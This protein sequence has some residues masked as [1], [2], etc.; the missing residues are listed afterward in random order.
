LAGLRVERLGAPLSE[1]DIDALAH[2]LL[3]AIGGNASIGFPAGTTL[4]QARAFWIGIEGDMAAGR[5]IVV[6]IRVDGSL[7]GTGQLRF[8]SYPNSRHRAEVAK[9]LVNSAVRRRGLATRLMAALEAEARD[10]GRTLLV[11]DTEAD[12]EA[13][14]MYVKLGWAKAGVI[15]DFAYRPDGQLRPSVFFYKALG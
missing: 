15:P 14:R 8:S 12:S 5:A 6:G 4:G 13:E 9:L 1:A 10:A 7:A 2:V 3:D 11:L